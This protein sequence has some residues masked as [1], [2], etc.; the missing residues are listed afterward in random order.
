VRGDLAVNCL[1][2]AR[3]LLALRDRSPLYAP[4]PA[5][6]TPRRSQREKR[7]AVG[8]HTPYTGAVALHPQHRDDRLKMRARRCVARS[9]LLD[10]RVAR[11]YFGRTSWA[12]S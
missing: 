1:R 10:Q 8:K 5:A 12:L 2:L 6:R 3:Q 7:S 11:G 4:P 9:A